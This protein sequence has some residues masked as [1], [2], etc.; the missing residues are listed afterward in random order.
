M[1]PILY[2]R[3]IEVCIIPVCMQLVAHL[4]KKH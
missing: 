2:L 1:D 3:E 4:E